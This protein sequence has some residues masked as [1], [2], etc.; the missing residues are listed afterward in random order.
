M[1][2]SLELR[3]IRRKRLWTVT[4]FATWMGITR[5]PAMALL[6][7]LDTELGGVLLRKSNGKKPEYS[8][9]PALLAKAKPELFEKIVSLEIRVDEHDERIEALEGS[10]RR[11]IS[12]VG[13]VTRCVEKLRRTG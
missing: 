4:D 5:K 3:R 8:F 7:A 13:Y 2:E 10:S 9:V 11:T 1:T 6:R 12:Q